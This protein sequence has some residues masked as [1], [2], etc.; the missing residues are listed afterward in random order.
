MKKLEHNTETWYNWTAADWHEALPTLIEKMPTLKMLKSMQAYLSGNGIPPTRN[1]IDTV[2]RCWN[3]TTGIESGK[4]FFKLNTDTRTKTSD[5]VN[6]K[7][8]LLF[9][10]NKYLHDMLFDTPIDSCNE[11]H[12]KLLLQFS[13]A[14]LNEYVVKRM[15]Q[16]VKSL[17]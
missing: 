12:N 10:N 13:K 8:M 17:I 2:I 7:T 3:K 11:L 15:C 16:I 6:R 14:E 5:N 4:E 1:Q 9:D